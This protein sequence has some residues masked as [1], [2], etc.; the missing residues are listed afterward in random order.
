MQAT[1]YLLMGFPGAGKTT[2]AKIIEQLTGAVRLSSDEERL[3]LWPR[4]TFSGPEHQKLYEYL[5]KKTEELLEK[6]ESVIYDA[7]LNRLVHR[8]EKYEL[9]R[10]TGASIILIW[11][12]TPRGVAKER[13]IE[14]AAHHQLVPKNEAPSSMF[15][16]IAGLIEVPGLNEPYIALDGTALTPQLIA[17]ALQPQDEA[18]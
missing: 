16:R 15:E 18:N 12:Q 17:K 10:N 11:V 7:N 14:A 9:A 1:L 5:D 4:P 8:Q 2:A 13:R 3:K 6:G